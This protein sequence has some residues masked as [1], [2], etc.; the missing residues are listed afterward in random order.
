MSTF[1]DLDSMWRDREAFPN[2]N[3]YELGPRKIDSWFR[4]ARTVRAFPMN[5]NLQPLEFSTT[6]NIKYMTI[7]Y[8]ETVADFPRLYVDFHSKKYRDIH[9]INSIEGRQSDAKFICVPEKIQNDV[10]GNP[11]WMHYRCTME[12]AMRFERGDQ[13]SVSIMTRN[14]TVLP[15]LDNPP[16]DEPDPSKQTLLTFEITPYIRDGDYDN[17]MVQTLSL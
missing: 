6:V 1:V 9:L 14:G 13:I 7:P 4:S 10:N 8:S 17:H 16:E 3:S 15:Q 5:P 12:Q 11:I 2:E